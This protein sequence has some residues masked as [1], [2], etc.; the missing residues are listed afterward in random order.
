[1]SALSTL[2]RMTRRTCLRLAVVAAVGLS[3]LPGC[4]SGETADAGGG[5]ADSTLGKWARLGRVWRELGAH[6]KKESGRNE[7]GFEKL[8]AEMAE[9]LQAVSASK[10][11][12]ALFETRAAHVDRATYSQATCYAPLP[13]GFPQPQF[14]IEEQVSQL[15][16]LADQGA[17]TQE[18]AEKAARVLAVQAEY[19]VRQGA[20]GQSTE[21]L[22]KSYNGGKLQPGPAADEAGKHTAEMTVDK[23]GW[24]LTSSEER[25]A[26]EGQ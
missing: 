4:R 20:G 10:E 12:R 16:K 7:K 11:L 15:E 21:A 5:E 14:R 6:L 2:E 25:K 17:L 24:L 23:L 22:R 18:A 13:P 8:K 3:W 1:M 26:P 9:A 19:I